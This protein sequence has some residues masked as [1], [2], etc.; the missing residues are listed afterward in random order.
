LQIGSSRNWLGQFL[1]D[2]ANS[3]MN[4]STKVFMSTGVAANNHNLIILKPYGLFL[5]FVVQVDFELNP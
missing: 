4:R 5:L 2:R 3:S 1:D